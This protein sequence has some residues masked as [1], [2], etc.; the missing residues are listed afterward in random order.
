MAENI[1]EALALEHFLP[2]VAR[3]IAGWMLRITRSA[4]DLPRMAASV[5][6]QEVRLPP[7]QPRRHVDLV[8]VGGE[9]HQRPFLEVEQRR[10]RIAVLLVLP[11][12]VTPVLARAGILQFDG[13]HRQPVHR[14]H[15]VERAV[16]AGMTRHLP[17]HGQPVLPNSSSTS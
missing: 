1:E 10:A 5:E 7:R 12:R 3:A 6:W 14:Q 4:Y 16:V 13:G 15:H 11:D 17:R 2:K 8:R 9:M